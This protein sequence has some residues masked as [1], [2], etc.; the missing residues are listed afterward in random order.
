M[1]IIMAI[2][3]KIIIIII[4]IIILIQTLFVRRAYSHSL[5]SKHAYLADLF[6]VGK[7]AVTSVTSVLG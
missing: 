7:T 4:S 2:L 6:D 3:T 5:I 1:I